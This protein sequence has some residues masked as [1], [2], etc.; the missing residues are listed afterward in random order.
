MMAERGK[1]VNAEGISDEEKSGLT[2][3]VSPEEAP[4]GA[5]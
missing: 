2:A 5:T 4:P 1:S 3:S